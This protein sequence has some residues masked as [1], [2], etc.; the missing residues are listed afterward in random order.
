MSMEYP[1][2]SW[3]IYDHEWGL[4]ANHEFFD[5]LYVFTIWGG[6]LPGYPIRQ[7]ISEYLANKD[8][9]YLPS[10]MFIAHLRKKT[11]AHRFCKN[12]CNLFPCI[13][14]LD[15]NDSVGHEALKV[16][17]F[18]CDVLFAKLAFS[19]RLHA[20]SYL[21][22]L[23]AQCLDFQKN[24]IL[25]WDVIFKLEHEENFPHKSHKW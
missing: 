19:G 5:R 21:G 16:V 18:D 4:W 17:V 13:H 24:W 14:M 23:H 22:F 11:R 12:I 10:V 2:N 3:F 25:P 1:R 6:N 8:T 9:F 7:V 20:Q 15:S